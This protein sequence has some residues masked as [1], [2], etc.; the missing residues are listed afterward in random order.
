VRELLGALTAAAAL[1]G[2]GATATSASAV[3]DACG[4]GAASSRYAYAGEQATIAAHGVRAT[5]T[6]LVAAPVT[7][8][9]VAAW[10]GV[11]GFQSGPR[12]ADVWL[13]AGVASLPDE[14]FLLYAEVM[15]AGAATPSFM[16]LQ[17]DVEVGESHRLAVL[18]IRG[19]ANWWRIWLDGRAATKP[20]HLAGSSG[21]WQP[22]ATAESQTTGGEACPVFAFRFASVQV[23]AA[24]GGSW[25]VFAHG[26]RL[27]DG[28]Y[29]L[30][31]LNPGGHAGF[32]FEASNR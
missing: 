32:S 8:G 12:G 7:S 11:G 29:R 21:S 15:R 3:A 23:A 25:Q 1:L 22:V 30:R 4:Q 16:E 6:P 10:V 26:R 9:H 31:L 20:M 28:G 18:E 19:R 24:L 5:I 14:P 13:Q 2:V 27:L 17:T